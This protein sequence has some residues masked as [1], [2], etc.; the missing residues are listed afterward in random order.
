MRKR[1][2]KE[3]VTVANTLG[4]APDECWTYGSPFGVKKNFFSNK[5]KQEKKEQRC[6]FWKNEMC[7][8]H[9]KPH[10]RGGK[11]PV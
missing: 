6:S 7:V 2:T 3:K 8:K 11:H 4:H 1:G 5:G 9:S 10:V